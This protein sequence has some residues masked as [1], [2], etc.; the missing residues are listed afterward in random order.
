MVEQDYITFRDSVIVAL[1]DEQEP[2]GLGAI[3]L[4]ELCKRHGIPFHDTWIQTVGAD[5]AQLG[6]GTD[7]S[8]LKGRLFQ[9]NGSGLARASEVRKAR[10]PLSLHGRI[11]T[12][13]RSEWISMLA[14][15]VSAIALFKGD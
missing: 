7:R 14:L 12:V 5:M 1:A 13:T 9:I 6:W 11:A 15:L 8:T 3:E 2:P 10:M 4:S